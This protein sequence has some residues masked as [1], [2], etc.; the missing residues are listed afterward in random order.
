MFNRLRFSA[1]QN[2]LAIKKGRFVFCYIDLFIEYLNLFKHKQIWIISD[3]LEAAKDNGFALFK[4]VIKQNNKN[5]KPY[6]VL[7]KNCEDYDIV[8][9]TESIKI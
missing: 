2:K 6:F 5:I 3:R 4:Y 9:N 7:L 8:K 1:R